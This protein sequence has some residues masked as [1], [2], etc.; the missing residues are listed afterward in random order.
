MSTATTTR[1][2]NKFH[3]KRCVIDGY[4]FDSLVEG[5]RYLDLKLLLR[6][7]EINILIVHPRWDLPGGIRYVGDFSY[8]E[9]GKGFVLEDVK[10]KPTRTPAYRMKKK[11]MAAAHNISIT[12]FCPTRPEADRLRDMAR[13]FEI[14]A[15]GRE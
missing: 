12:E 15:R 4:T 13:P 9:K 2:T 11:L 8:I 14:T 1:K 10:A 6:A 7:K 3:A 5:G